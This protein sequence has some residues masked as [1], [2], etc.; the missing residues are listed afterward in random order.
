[1]KAERTNAVDIGRLN[2]IITEW[3]RLIKSEQRGAYLS[4][5]LKAT[6][7]SAEELE[8]VWYRI[9]R[10]NGITFHK[11]YRNGVFFD[12]LLSYVVTGA[13]KQPP[14]SKN[15]SEQNT[16]SA[17][18][19]NGSTIEDVRMLTQRMLQEYRTNHNTLDRDL[20]RLL[21]E[22]FIKVKSINILANNHPE[23]QKEDI[24]HHVRSPIRLPDTLRA[25]NE[26]G[27][28]QDPE[29][30]LH[31]ALFTVNYYD[32]D[33]D[34]NMSDKI[35]HMAE[36]MA[37]YVAA[38]GTVL[39]NIASGNMLS[40][41]SKYPPQSNTQYVST[42]DAIWIATATLHIKYGMDAVF[43]D[44]EIENTVK[45]QGL[46]SPTNK[47]LHWNVSVHCV[48]NMKATNKSAHR[49]LYKV[50]I[51]TY[52]LY[53]R[54]EPHDHTRKGKIAPMKF[55]IPDGYKHLRKWYDELYCKWDYTS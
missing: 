9:G 2:Y 35:L 26:D 29:L 30:S 23:L 36:S 21:T 48:A 53:K 51:R 24:K 44:S 20:Q 25:R 16:K 49:K 37:E 39:E 31:I 4:S 13:E 32:W 54:G 10:V 42:P 50:A 6:D 28:H 33:G 15:E 45:Q 19:R 27:L 18:G 17:L 52:R 22:E 8:D 11:T 55:Q 14:T 1:M 12:F 7:T 46:C 41:P 5:L 3:V 43:L 34:A 40:I 47:T 38:H